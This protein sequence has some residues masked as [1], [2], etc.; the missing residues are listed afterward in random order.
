MDVIPFTSQVGEIY[1]YEWSINTYINWET[2][3]DTGRR[4][5]GLAIDADVLQGSSQYEVSVRGICFPLFFFI[6]LCFLNIIPVD[7]SGR[8]FHTVDT[9][10]V[11]IQV[12]VIH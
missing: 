3:S 5:L 4:Y 11:G 12:S 1:A 2:Q 6:Y 8:A 9:N 7:I 10:F